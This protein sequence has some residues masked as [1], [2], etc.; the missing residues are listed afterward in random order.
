MQSTALFGLPQLRL[1]PMWWIKSFS[2]GF[3]ERM[4]GVGI[5]GKWFNAFAAFMV[6]QRVARS[7][8]AGSSISIFA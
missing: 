1:V 7:Q 6:L 5:S 8:V 3:H 4:L 2:G